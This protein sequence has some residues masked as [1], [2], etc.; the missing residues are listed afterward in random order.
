MKKNTPVT[1]SL[2]T[3]TINYKTEV[4]AFSNDHGDR[5]NFKCL[6]TY[7][8]LVFKCRLWENAMKVTSACVSFVW[9]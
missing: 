8:L 6:M 5:T 7:F 4:T 9:H 1:D 2:K 3:L